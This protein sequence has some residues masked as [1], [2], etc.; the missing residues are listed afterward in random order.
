MTP[1]KSVSK[2]RFLLNPNFL[3]KDGVKSFVVLPY[4]EFLQIQEKLEDYQ[5][6]MDLRSAVQQERNAP[7]I[8]LE[9][10]RKQVNS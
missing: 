4:E 6:L 5:D 2:E 1:K 8:S 7:T 9:E 3:E 10:A